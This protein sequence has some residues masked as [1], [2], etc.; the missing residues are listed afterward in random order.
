MSVLCTSSSTAASVA[1]KVAP[2]QALS[3][4]YPIEF[5]NRWPR[6]R[7]SGRR[8]AASK[9]ILNTAPGLEAWF[10]SSLASAGNCYKHNPKKPQSPPFFSSQRPKISIGRE[11]A[12]NTPFRR[13]QSTGGA[14]CRKEEEEDDG[15]L[16]QPNHTREELMELVDQYDGQPFTF[17]DEIPFTKRPSRYQPPDGPHLT[18]SDKAED[19]WPPVYQAWPADPQTKIKLNE[20][21]KVITNRYGDPEIAY[22]LY[23]ELPKP[24]APY[25]EATVRHRLLRCLSTVERK[26]EIS[27]LRYLSVVDDMKNSAIPLSTTEWNSAI[28]FISRYVARST[29]V[30]VEA[31]LNLWKE[32]E[33]VA[34]VKASDATFNILFD[35]AC[36][37]GKFTLADMV[38]NEMAARGLEYN[39]FHHVSLIHYHGLKKDGDGARAAYKTLVDAGEVVDTVVLNSMISALI[40]SCE[41][42]AAENIYE[43]MKKIH[44]SQTEPRLPPNDFIKQ[45]RITRTLKQMAQKIKIDPHKRERFQIRSIIAPDVHTYRILVNYFAVEAGELSKAAKLLE[46]MKSFGLPVH[47]ALF[48]ALLKGFAIHGGIRYTEW[49]EE[50]LESVWRTFLRAIDGDT[51]DL[52]I[53]RW[54][55]TWALNA[56]AK[57]SGKSRTM[58]VW[59]EVREKWQPD[60]LELDFVLGTLRPLLEAKDMAEARHDWILGSL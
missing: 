13:Q 42:N 18:V 14:K 21:D 32:M 49:T 2:R 59:E 43:R 10:I 23:R 17:A 35:V 7:R 53:N 46:E 27:M 26:D 44:F 15:F 45:R 54:M 60:E 48:L 29:E 37:A 22:Q 39:R 25:L 8:Q 57:C 56:F 47:G 24:R 1:S 30:E 51:N 41:P 34:L 38:Y 58:A 16:A 52:Y 28:S 4:L 55:V 6:P 36:K 40:S 50:R 20:L 5:Q 19:E 31:A 33:Q 12:H 3:F 11:L 9:M